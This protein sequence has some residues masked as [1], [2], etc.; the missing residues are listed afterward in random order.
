MEKSVTQQDSSNT[1]F[2]RTDGQS[3][4]VKGCMRRFWMNNFP[5]YGL[6]RHEQERHLQSMLIGKKAGIKRAL[7]P[8]Q[9]NVRRA[10]WDVH[11]DP[12]IL[13]APQPHWELWRD[14]PCPGSHRDQVWAWRQDVDPGRFSHFCCEKPWL[15]VV[16]SRR[17]KGF[18]SCYLKI[19]LVAV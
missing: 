5:F 9:Q 4:T 6:D 2:Y 13:D 12:D 19:T 18:G 16:I 3:P 11:T 1:C 7:G 15:G 8:L 10:S 17:V 14:S